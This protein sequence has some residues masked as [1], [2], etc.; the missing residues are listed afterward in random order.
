MADRLD[1]GRLGDLGLGERDLG[2]RIAGSGGQQRAIG[3]SRRAVVAF[4]KGQIARQCQQFGRAGMAGQGVGNRAF[5]LVML[6]LPQQVPRQGHLRGQVIGIPL[7]GKPVAP[8]GFGRLTAF[9]TICA[10][11]SRPRPS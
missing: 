4:A 1:V 7:Q 9:G 5:G 11:C 8:F 3:R 6:V 10:T 2:P